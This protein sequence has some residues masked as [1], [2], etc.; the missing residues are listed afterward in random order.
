MGAWNVSAIAAVIL[1]AVALH[2]PPGHAHKPIT[3][4]YTFNEHVFPILRQ[5]CLQCHMAGGAGPM[6]LATHAEAVPWGE[7]IRMELIAGHMPPWP[8]TSAPGRFRH[9]GALTGRELNVLLTW[10]S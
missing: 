5:R 6:S 7:S 8:V 10:A 2:A 1:A 9:A 4:P 3:S